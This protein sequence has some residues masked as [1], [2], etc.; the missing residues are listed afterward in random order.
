MGGRE[1][2]GRGILPPADVLYSQS[3]GHLPAA[4][5]RLYSPTQH[6]PLGGRSAS[7][8][9]IFDTMRISVRARHA[10]RLADTHVVILITILST[11]QF[12]YL[13][14]YYLYR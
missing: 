3:D 4:D 1:G 5:S 6:Q 11:D 7:C 10:I 2:Q 14:R 9:D 13:V 8:K 12:I